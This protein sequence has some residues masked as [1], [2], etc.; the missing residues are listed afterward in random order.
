MNA[1][2]LCN[3]YGSDVKAE[4]N[5]LP[6][7]LVKIIADLIV[8]DERE[9]L[10]H[11]WTRDHK[12]CQLLCK[13]E[14]HVPKERLS[15]LREKFSLEIVESDE[16]P[17]ESAAHEDEVEERLQGYLQTGAEW[18]GEHWIQ[19]QA[20]FDRVSKRRF[21]GG[22]FF[23]ESNGL[24]LKHFGLS[25]RAF[26]TTSNT[27][28]EACDVLKDQ[29]DPMATVA[30]LKLADDPGFESELEQGCEYEGACSFS[31]P[32]LSSAIQKR[33]NGALKTLRLRPHASPVHRKVLPSEND[34]AAEHKTSEWPKL[35]VFLRDINHP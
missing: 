7:E 29:Q 3:R 9:R 22:S 13:P 33:F 8:K 28:D 34:E 17:Q 2:K 1:L 15:Q 21:G 14:D 35:T 23:Q 16:G 26:T 10:R 5:K 20:W 27:P 19:S 18:L 4:V 32:H 12:C 11:L 25:V 30:W 24:I 6:T 31:P